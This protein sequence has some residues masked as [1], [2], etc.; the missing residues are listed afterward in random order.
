MTWNLNTDTVVGVI[1]AG[2]MGG[3]IAQLAAQSGHAVR[4]FDAQAGAAERALTRIEADLDASV[5]KGRLDTHE[6]AA[7]R[8]RLAAVESLAALA[9]CG[10]IVEAIV[11]KLDAKQALFK[12]LEGVLEAGA[13]LATNTSS[14]SITAVAQGL[15]HPERL[16]GWHFFNPATRMKL[17]EVI[18]GVET[19]HDLV[20]AL[21][22]LGKAWGK[23]S[24]DAPNAPGFIV[25]RV[26]RPYYAEG[27]RLLA[28]RIAAPQAIDRVLREA[29]G[30]ALGP[31]ELMDLIGTDVNLSVTESVFA[32][33]GWDTR[34]A[35]NLI[36]QELVRAG[37]YGR[38]SGRGF[39]DYRDGAKPPLAPAVVPVVHAPGNAL[40]VRA[41]EQS[42][43]LS[44]LV[45][46]LRFADVPIETDRSL[47]PE[48]LR[49]GEIVVALTD[50]R[51]LAERRAETAAPMLL[52]DLA[53]DYSTTGLLAATGADEALAQFAA[54]LQPAKIELIALADVAGLVLMRTVAC[55]ANEAA[56]VMTWSGTTAVDIDVA[57][58]LGTAYPIGPLAWADAIGV[59]RVV[60]VLANLQAHYGDVRYRR[61]PQLAAKHFAKVGFHG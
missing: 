17:V 42:G 25:N 45:E 44:P 49:I 61:S 30:F 43:L 1:G 40:Q 56:D 59:S 4:L 26:A 41:G 14:I 19:D 15:A 16:V 37:R 10:L 2:S 36:Q 51:T 13:V 29:G 6:R 54:V 31:F 58:R 60:Q 5:Q 11:E 33:T 27:L 7:V 20:V 32:A 24:V 3:G 21:H 52:L 50:G 55:L 18:P 38:K 12:Q 39:Y 53:R 8:A 23:S 48:T 57:M 22:A 34:Y 35:P 28:E 9:G 46:R 47:A